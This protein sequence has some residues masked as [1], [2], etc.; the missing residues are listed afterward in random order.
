MGII[1]LE[2]SKVFRQVEFEAG[3]VTEICQ[4]QVPNK[5]I[6]TC[7]SRC[8]VYRYRSFGNKLPETRLAALKGFVFYYRNAHGARAGMGSQR[9]PYSR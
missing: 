8:G 1:A 9:S 4:A 6:L 2:Y 5:Q 3:I 7:L